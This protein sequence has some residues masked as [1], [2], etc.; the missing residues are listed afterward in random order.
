MNERTV[1]KD[2]H[3]ALMASMWYLSWFAHKLGPSKGSQ[4]LYMALTSEARA[5]NP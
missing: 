2:W 3:A 1:R 4:F 5:L